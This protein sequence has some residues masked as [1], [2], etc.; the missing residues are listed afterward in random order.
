MAE[1]T[2]NCTEKT[3]I[4]RLQK[5]FNDFFPYLKIKVF[6]GKSNYALDENSTLNDANDGK[7]PTNYSHTI[8][9]AGKTLT[10]GQIEEMFEE[11]NNIRVKVYFTMCNGKEGFVDY[12]NDPDNPLH[13]ISLSYLNSICEG[14]HCK[15]SI[16]K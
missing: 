9:I 6:K 15:K 12:K 10:I 14:W 5:A 11:A 1:T 4:G 2:F 16:W 13:R 7:W 8:P 3:K